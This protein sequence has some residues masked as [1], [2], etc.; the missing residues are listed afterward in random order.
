M[1]ILSTTYL[2]VG[3]KLPFGHWHLQ[4]GEDDHEVAR[5][6]FAVKIRDERGQE[7]LIMLVVP[8]NG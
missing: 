5:V 3:T 2:R 7:F 8:S 1:L 6:L 4:D